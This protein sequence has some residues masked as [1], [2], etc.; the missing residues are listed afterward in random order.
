VVGKGSPWF[1]FADA[2]A[3]EQGP[4]IPT[5]TNDGAQSGRRVLVIDDHPV[6]RLG[7]AALLRQLHGVDHVEEAATATAALLS[8]RKRTFA[9]VTLDLSLPDMDGFDLLIRAREEGLAGSVMVLSMHHERAYLSRARGEGAVGYAAKSAG[10][11]A[12]AACAARCLAGERT[13][14]TA[15]PA[16]TKTPATAVR[17]GV[18]RLSPSERRVIALLARGLTSREMAGII[19]VSV[20]TI[21]N[22]RANICRKLGLRGPHRLLEFALAVE[23]AHLNDGP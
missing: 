4:E 13:F 21:E 5:M 14:P 19:G 12:V 11:T 20:R 18:E 3:D 6:F 17:D 1:L 8:W 7:L 2:V 23:P 22:H 15:L 9:L 16:E 10:A